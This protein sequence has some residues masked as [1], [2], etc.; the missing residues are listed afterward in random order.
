MG[1]L[2]CRISGSLGKDGCFLAAF[3]VRPSPVSDRSS[4][5]LGEDHQT[6]LAGRHNFAA[7]LYAMGNCA[8]AHTILNSNVVRPSRGSTREG[9]LST[10]GFPLLY[11]CAFQNVTELFHAECES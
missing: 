3:T 7:A 2:G 10:S 9:V 4:E 8:Q 11:V 6:T 1:Q 5:V